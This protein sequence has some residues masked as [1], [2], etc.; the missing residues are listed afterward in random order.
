MTSRS[1]SSSAPASADSTEWSPNWSSW[2]S[3][4]SRVTATTSRLCTPP[5]DSDTSSEVIHVR[6]DCAFICHVLGAYSICCVRRPTP[7]R[8]TTSTSARRS[9]RPC[10]GAS[11]TSYNCCA[12][13]ASSCPEFKVGASISKQVHRFNANTVM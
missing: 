4:S 7:S 1:R 5:Q 2:T 12:W 6:A 10:T 11:P 3:A 9:C 8:G 13:K